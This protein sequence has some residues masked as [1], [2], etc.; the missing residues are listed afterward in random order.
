[1]FVRHSRAERNADDKHPNISEE[2]VSFFFMVEEQAKETQ[3]EEGGKLEQFLLASLFLPEDGE[4][5]FL[6]NVGL[7][8][9]YVVLQLGSRGNQNFKPNL[10]EISF[11]FVGFEVI[12]AVVMEVAILWDVTS[13]RP[14]ACC[15]IVCLI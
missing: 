8:P 14:A 1:L 4:N 10:S 9:N 12:T 2:H 15:T 7:F 11:V 13:C 5:I 3:A 6:R